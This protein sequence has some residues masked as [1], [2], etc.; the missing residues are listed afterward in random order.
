M[1]SRSIRKLFA[2]S[3]MAVIATQVY[4]MGH[5]PALAAQCSAAMQAAERLIVVTVANEDGP[6]AIIERFERAAPDQPWLAVGGMLQA[7]VGKKGAAWG[8]GY[9]ELANTGEPLKREGDLKSPMG[10][11]WLGATFGFDEATYPGHMKLELGRHLCVE[12]PR[13]QSYGRI[14]DSSVVEKGA[15]F[16]EMAVEKLYRKGVVVD[17]PA[18]AAN[19]AGSCIFIHVWRGPGKGTAGCVALDE[20]NVA[21]LQAWTSEKPSA[22][23]IL[24]PAAKARFGACLP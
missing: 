19:K 23:A 22:I 5:R 17:Y 2:A 18:D 14:V 15:G 3:F 21:D 6:S 10:I 11:Y 13:S 24:T 12:D 16:D 7:V 4:F 1:T 9:R 8:A 20:A